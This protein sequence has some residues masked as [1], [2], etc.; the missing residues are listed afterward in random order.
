M[1]RFFAVIGV[2]ALLYAVCGS[3]SEAAAQSAPA[4]YRMTLPEPQDIER[5]ITQIR[6]A[7]SELAADFRVE[8]IPSA[9]E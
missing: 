5:C 8:R 7:V 9:A 6:D 4:E 2:F 1:K 3:K